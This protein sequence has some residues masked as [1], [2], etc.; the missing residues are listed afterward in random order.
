[1][2]VDRGAAS[3]LREVGLLPDGPVLWG[4]PLTPRAHR[5][6]PPPGRNPR[7][8]TGERQ[9]H[10]I[11]GAVAPDETLAPP[12]THLVAVPPGDAD[13]ARKEDLGTGA[14]RRGPRAAPPPPR[15]R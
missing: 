12:P 13:G 8:P 11:T 14:R 9:A 4:R 6:P 7:R 2:S 5:A 15:A 3:L 1:M 10:G